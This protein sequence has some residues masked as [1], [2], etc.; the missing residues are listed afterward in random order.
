[1]D[2]DETPEPDDRQTTEDG[3]LVGKGL[4][5]RQQ[6]RGLRDREQERIGAASVDRRLLAPRLHAGP[7]RATTTD[8]PGI[9]AV[10]P[11]D[12]G[13]PPKP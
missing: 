8:D 6:P 12:D 2:P 11:L 7:H 13:C 10:P 1:M 3:E 4:A 5:D 9:R